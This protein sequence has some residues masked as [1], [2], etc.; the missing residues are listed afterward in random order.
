M[1]LPA[2]QLDQHNVPVVYRL[3]DRFAG[4]HIQ[5]P[6]GLSRAL[7]RARLSGNQHRLVHA[8]L[9]EQLRVRRRVEGP[10]G[11][12]QPIGNRLLMEA[13]GLKS[14]T[15]DREVRALEK[16]GI[17]LIERQPG[18]GRGH[19]QNLYQIALP[20]LWDPRCLVVT[21]PL[22]RER[23]TPLKVEGTTPLSVEG[24]GDGPLNK[25]LEEEREKKN[26]DDTR[27]H[28]GEYQQR[29]TA[30]QGKEQPAESRDSDVGEQRHDPAQDDDSVKAF[31]ERLPK[32][33]CSLLT[34][35]TQS[36]AG[37][38]IR[39]ELRYPAHL[40]ALQTPKNLEAVHRAAAA[41][42]VVVEL[43]MAERQAA[44]AVAA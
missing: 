42:G 38:V 30:R 11:G 31:R 15:I 37:K 34:D 24:T 19:R 12:F 32:P 2:T 18:E 7:A 33:V 44:N 17:L 20:H 41:A 28:V 29:Q 36:L 9:Q 27:R 3:R 43:V 13:T 23:R 6:G 4:E 39:F 22:R 25:S 21:T 1:T 26:H 10:R 35:S 14:S 5:V 16:L 40:E 8:V